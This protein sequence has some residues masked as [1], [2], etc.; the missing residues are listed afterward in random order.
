MVMVGVHVIGAL[1]GVALGIGAVYLVRMVIEGARRDRRIQPEEMVPGLQRDDWKRLEA[2]MESEDAAERLESFAILERYGREDPD[3]RED[4]IEMTCAYLRKPFPYPSEDDEELEVR[5]AAQGLLTRHFRWPAGE[6]RPVE[7]WEVEELN[8][9]DAVLVEPDFAD[10]HL[11]ETNLQDS[12]I[13]RGDFHGARFSPFVSFERACF[14]G[15]TDF[16]AASF[17][18]HTSFV[19]AM[20]SGPTTFADAEFEQ[21]ADFTGARVEQPGATHS[22]PSP[23]RA[24]VTSPVS[25]ARLVSGNDG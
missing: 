25:Q 15:D 1:A 2:M 14:T 11:V 16:R 13:V 19:D 6:A 18:T 22:W 20:F 23:W 24:W 12:L 4:V 10:T 17:P 9:R 7:F 5:R 21:D 8:L 3:V